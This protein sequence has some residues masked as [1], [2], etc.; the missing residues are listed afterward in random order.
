MEPQNHVFSSSE[1]HPRFDQT[2]DIRRLEFKVKLNNNFGLGPQNSM[3]AGDR[4]H[5]FNKSWPNELLCSFSV[6][7]KN[8]GPVP[9]GHISCLSLHHQGQKCCKCWVCSHCLSC[10][11]QSLYNCRSSSTNEFFSPVADT[12]NQL[13]KDALVS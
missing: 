6:F 8:H 1:Q 10:I 4:K 9:Q 5:Y 7:T 3:R 13:E 11:W 12:N 2:V